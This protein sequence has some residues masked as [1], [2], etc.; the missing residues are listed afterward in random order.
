MKGFMETACKE[1]FDVN[2]FFKGYY[3]F[4]VDFI[5]FKEYI[6]IFVEVN[7]NSPSEIPTDIKIYFFEILLQFITKHNTGSKLQPI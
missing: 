7:T 4:P 2:E 6:R 5:S 1:L 3:G